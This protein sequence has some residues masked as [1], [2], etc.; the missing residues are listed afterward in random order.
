[1]SALHVYAVISFQ[2]NENQCIAKD[3]R[4]VL[5]KTPLLSVMAR[6][7]LFGLKL[8][9]YGWKKCRIKNININNKI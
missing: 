4:S 7:I 6:K 3:N 1:M 2:N 9:S 8:R 5:R